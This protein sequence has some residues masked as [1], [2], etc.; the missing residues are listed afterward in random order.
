MPSWVATLEMSEA[1]GIPP[2]QV[3]DQASQYWVERFLCYRA[4]TAKEQKRQ[5]EK[6]KRKMERR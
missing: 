5:A 1:W 6:S 3:D 2:W 4:E